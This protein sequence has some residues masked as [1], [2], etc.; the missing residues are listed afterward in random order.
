MPKTQSKYQLIK[1]SELTPYE[2]NARTHSPEQIEA[3]CNSI[4]EFGFIN[5]VIID[6]NNMILVGHG[7]IEAAKVLGLTEAPY[8][9]VENLTEDQKRAY[10][11]ADNKL[12]DLGGWNEEIL[13]QELGEIE[14][15]MSLFGFDNIEIGALDIDGNIEE[16]EIPE[17]KEDQEPKAK[18]GDIYKLGKNFLM[19]GDATSEDDIRALLSYNG[20]GNKIM[21][22]TDPPYGISIVNA[23]SAKEEEVGGGG[24]T[25]F[26]K[27]GGGLIVDAKTYR[28]VK[29]DDTT[30]T[31][32]L[33]YEIVKELTEN[34]II[35]GG[36]YFTDFLY[37]SSCWVVWDKEINGNFADA[38]LAWTSFNKAV[39][40]YKH[41]WNGMSREG[42]RDL[43]GKT[44]V[45]PTQKPVGMLSKVIQDFATA[46]EVILDCFG[47]SGS[48]LI[49]CEHLGRSC[50]MLEYE[51]YYIDV[52]IERWENLTGKKAELIKEG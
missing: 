16:D 49:A 11:L 50:F 13:S 17:I 27:V 40:L 14:L 37:P 25:K 32:R 39:K 36:N 48:T 12:S 20:G 47:G 23:K 35:F 28:E 6:E 44:R 15:D 29:G 22:L 18:R 21:L 38:E 9:R 34:Q 33:N 45:H 8:R 43:E 30:D 1:I 31:A 10:I 41:L 24:V 3:I 4:K 26:G 7:R 2:N 52:I 5:P 51:P 46:G 19:C 42:S